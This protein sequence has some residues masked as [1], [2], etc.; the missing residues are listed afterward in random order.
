MNKWILIFLSGLAVASAQPDPKVI[1]EVMAASDAW[2]QAMMKKDGA[3]LQ[4]LLHNDIT[5]SHSNGRNQTKAEV[6]EA[7]TTGKTT[8]EAMDF[9]DTTVRV[10]GTTA[11]IRA[12]VEMRNVTDGKATTFHINVLHVWQKGAGGWQMIARQATQVSP[13]TVQ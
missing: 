8:I 5:Y 13:P 3:A 12:N 6:A 2:K 9:S 4:R 10:F 1:K 7:T 11:L